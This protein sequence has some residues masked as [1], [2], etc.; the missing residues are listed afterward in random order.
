MLTDKEKLLCLFK[1]FR[2]ELIVLMNGSEMSAAA[3]AYGAML[4]WNLELGRKPEDLLEA[5]FQ[6][7]DQVE[8]DKIR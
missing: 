8:N 3:H 4:Q 5:I 2:S 6:V 7:W 1:N